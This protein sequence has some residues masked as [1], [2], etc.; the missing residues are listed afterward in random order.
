[1]SGAIY[2]NNLVYESEGKTERA[3]SQGHHP[4]I[5]FIIFL[6]LPFVQVVYTAGAG[7]VKFPVAVVVFIVHA[8]FLLYSVTPIQEVIKGGAGYLSG[9]SGF[10]G[11]LPLPGTS[12]MA[13]KSSSVY[14]ASC[15]KGLRPARRSRLLT[16]SFGKLRF[17]AIS[18]IVIPVISLFIGILIL[19][20]ENVHYKEHLYK[21]M[22]SEN[23]KKILKMSV[24]RNIYLD[25]MFIYMDN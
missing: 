15:E 9:V 3:G 5:D 23:R 1:M 25:K 24:E 6:P 19:F 22:C 18:E 14:R 2:R 13:S 20:F 4:F 12:R 17:S 10:L 16:V 8:I 7:F 21:Q 11:G